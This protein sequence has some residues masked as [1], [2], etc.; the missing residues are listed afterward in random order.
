MAADACSAHRRT[1]MTRG[2]P[3]RSVSTVAVQPGS[4][5]ATAAGR[6]LAL[7]ATDLEQ[8]DAAVGEG[9]RQPLQQRRM[10]SSP[11]GPPSSAARGSNE[12]AIGSPSIAPDRT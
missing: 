6:L 10:T 1:R 9:A 12:V 11:S 2:N 7:V 4:T 3:P 5:V 8:R